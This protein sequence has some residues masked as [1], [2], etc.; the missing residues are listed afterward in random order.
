MAVQQGENV[1]GRQRRGLLYGNATPGY[2]INE[3]IDK[4]MAELRNVLKGLRR[5]ELVAAKEHDRVRA[6]AR[7]VA[8]A[9]AQSTPRWTPKADGRA[10]PTSSSGTGVSKS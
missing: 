7:D 2:D 1:N 8:S 5:A 4:D 9:Q 10:A 6:A 3:L